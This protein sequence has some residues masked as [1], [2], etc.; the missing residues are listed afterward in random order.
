M[1]IQISRFTTNLQQR[2][3]LIIIAFDNELYLRIKTI[4]RI[5]MESYDSFVS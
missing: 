4:Q 3:F 1:C 5:K 2:I